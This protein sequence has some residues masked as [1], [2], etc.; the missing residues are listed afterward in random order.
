MNKRQTELYNNLM[1][2]Y[3]GEGTFFFTDQEM[4]G[5]DYRIFSYHIASYSEFL[6]P[7]ALECRGHMFQMKDGEP[8]ALVSV[9]LNKFFNINENPFT[10]DLD[11]SNPEFIIEKLDGSLIS[12]YMCND[13]VRMKSKG[14]LHSVQAQAAQKL[15]DSEAYTEFRDMVTEYERYGF[16]VIMEYTA[17]DNRIVLGYSEPKLTVLAAR[18]VKDLSY[19]S[20]DWLSSMHQ[21]RNN[22]AEDFTLKFSGRMDNFIDEVRDMLHIEGFILGLANGQ[23]VKIKTDE[24]VSLHRT[25]DSVNSPRRLFECVIQGGSDDLKSLFADDGIAVGLINDMEALVQREFNNLI[26]EVNGFY[27]DNKDLE[28]KEYAILGQQ[29]LS[30]PLFGLAMQRYTGKEIDY[31]SFMIKNYK[32]YGI[33]DDTE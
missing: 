9:P 6:Q 2:L 5:N 28:R 4:D 26:D 11:L 19:V 21:F 22:M 32:L 10:M 31:K 18:S 13:K 20:W 25:K 1:N 8:I 24:Y 23:R 17:P 16:T 30:R 29:Q 12:T 15:F 7:D 27:D 14:S 3:E 33:G